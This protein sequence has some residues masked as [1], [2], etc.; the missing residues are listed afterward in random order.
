V[1][2]DAN[3]DHKTVPGALL[4][5]RR[6]FDCLW[7]FLIWAAPPALLHPFQNTPFVD[8]WVYA[9]PVQRL[10]EHGDLRMLDYSGSLNLVQ[11]LWG[12]IFCLP[13]GFS[14]TALRLSTWL[15]AA[16]C[17][18]GTYL[19][20]QE[21]RVSRRDSLIA[22][23]ALGA[24]PIFFVLSY[25]FMTDVPFLTAMIWSLLA[26]GRALR[27]QHDGW[28]WVAV[29]FAAMSVGI[30]VVGFVLPVAMMIA[31]LVHVGPWGRRGARF[32]WPT[33][34]FAFFGLLTWWHQGHTEHIAD[35]TL[36]PNAPETR[37]R[38]LIQYGLRLLPSMMVDTAT[39]LA[40][41]MG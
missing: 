3:H 19:L 8:D 13:L 11:I 28:L 38:Y 40:G 31:L 12:A 9:W 23:A 32:L 15:C 36:I 39:F 1:T 4:D 5:R 35:L 41:A 20:L 21:L 25:T 27:R 22:T 34:V 6:V 14:F 17:L 33:V 18:W 2:L 10:I 16:A 7:I 29:F 26:F 24:Y 30:R 37:I